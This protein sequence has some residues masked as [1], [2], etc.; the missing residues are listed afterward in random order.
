MKVYSNLSYF[1][2]KHIL[3]HI[4]CFLHLW[5]C[6]HFWMAPKVRCR[7]QHNGTHLGVHDAMVVRGVATSL[8]TVWMMVLMIGR[9]RHMRCSSPSWPN[10]GSRLRRHCKKRQ[11]PLMQPPQTN[12]PTNQHDRAHPTYSGLSHF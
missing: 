11:Q 8:D 10:R 4:A 2:F 1:F 7:G 5:K 3:L 6:W 12:L 9:G